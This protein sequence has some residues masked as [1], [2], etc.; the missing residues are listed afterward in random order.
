[1]YRILVPIDSSEARTT[2]QVE[3]VSALPHGS[4]SVEVTLLRVFADQEAAENT[5][6]MQLSTGKMAEER[7][8]ASGLAVE[9]MARHGDPAE[10][11]LNA[12]AEIDADLIVLGGRKRSPL[13]SLVFGSVS[14]AVTLDATRPVV[15]TGGIEESEPREGTTTAAQRE[16]PSHRCQNCGEVYYKAPSEPITR[17]RSCGSSRIQPIE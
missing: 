4:D 1:M 13:G 16:E 7:L 17:C 6:V 5:S 3:A 8:T 15:I 14:Q 10:Q 12:A 9:T 11:I 2:A